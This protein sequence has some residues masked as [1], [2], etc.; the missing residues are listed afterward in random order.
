MARQE[1]TIM[2]RFTALLFF[3]LFGPILI[4]NSLATQRIVVAELFTNTG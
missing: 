1:G 2:R 4:G 3:L